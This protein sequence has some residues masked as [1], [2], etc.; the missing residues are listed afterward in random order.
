MYFFKI[1]IASAI[2]FDIKKHRY[3][4]AKPQYLPTAKANFECCTG[5][6]D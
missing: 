6:T 5:K 2:F 3:T 1:P 4:S